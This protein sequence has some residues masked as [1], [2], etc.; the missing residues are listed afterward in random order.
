MPTESIQN[1]LKAI[2]RLSEGGG[3]VTTSALARELG[4][5]PASATLM[6]KRLAERD[7]VVHEPYRGVALSREGERIAVEMVR[8]H[9]LVERFLAEILGVP[10]DEVHD[11]AE[12]WE[13]LISEDIERRMDAALGF[14]TSDPHGSP[15]PSHDGA[16]AAR[17][18][19]PM[20]DLRAGQSAVVA[21]VSD[22][23]ASLLRYVG[24]LGL[25]PGAAVSV[26]DDEPAG[27]TLTI[28]V[29]RKRHTIGRD[30]A[31]ELLVSEVAG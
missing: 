17:D 6:I 21:E 12:K 18:A 10:W 11:E 4:I 16:F 27:G 9:R 22:K 5:A 1:Y 7:L 26:V 8:H 31:R 25:Y 29:G 2:Y 15:I 23:D 19:L 28:A 13:H 14:P 24:S 30:V 20:A 3:K